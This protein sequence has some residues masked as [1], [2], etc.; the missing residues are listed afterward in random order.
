[1]P[2]RRIA[3]VSRDV[4]PANSGGI[5]A[6]VSALLRLLGPVA[7][8]VLFTREGNR[9]QL[10][11]AIAAG[12]PI[13]PGGDVEVVYVRDDPENGPGSFYTDMHRYSADVHDALVAHYGDHGPDL[14]E[15]PDYLGEGAVTVQAARTGGA[16]FR[17]TAVVVR[18]HTSVEMCSV[19][20]GHLPVEF[21]SRM[22]FELE[23]YALRYA[24][25]VLVGGGDIGGTYDRFYAGRVA[26][27]ETIRHPYLHAV[28]PPSPPVDRAHDDM[29]HLLYL[30][31]LERR[32]GIENLV[33]VI[34]DTGVGVVLTIVG[35]DTNTAPRGISV[36]EHLELATPHDWRIRFHDAVPPEDVPGLFAGHDAV[37]LPSLWE[38]WPNVGLEGL[39]AGLPLIATP[40]GGLVEMV[41]APDDAG[42]RPGGWLSRDPGRPA[43]AER[44]EQLMEEPGT[45][46]RP[47]VG[48]RARAQFEALTAEGPV[49]EAYER[50]AAA[51]AADRPRR[52]ASGRAAP[53][54]TVVV[55]YYQLEEHVEETVASALAQTHRN[56]RVVIVNDGSTAP[57]DRVLVELARDPRVSVVTQANTGLGAARN[58]GIRVSSSDYVLPLDADNVL[59]PTFV[60]RALEVLEADPEMAFVT[61]WSLYVDEHGVPHEGIDRGYQPIGNSSDLVRENNVAGDAVALFRRSVFDDGYWYDEEL[62]SF[63]DWYHYWRLHDAGRVGHV[64]PERLFR[65][66]VRSSSMIREFGIDST[67]RLLGEMQSRRRE[68]EVEWCPWNA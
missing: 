57:E 65:Y 3:I 53:S 10:D 1:M 9:A 11:E 60:A 44:L 35:G 23:R 13:A 31:R 55:P 21:P 33:R 63:E 50:L 43:L 24:D 39:A 54:V 56:T 41:G 48:E 19:L 47:Q 59:E 46:R 45:V 42:D 6:Y 7:D 27:L 36:R 15:F 4:A 37:V 12:S 51:G 32:K 29:L 38:C 67:A 62:T 22:T 5:A 20:D 66:R 28:Q 49:L 8:V 52:A 25:A 40:V 16:T 34:R 58:L 61:S 14:V 18:A 17:D 26:R 2:D 68:E 64:I 30:G